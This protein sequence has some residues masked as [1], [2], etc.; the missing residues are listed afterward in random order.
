MSAYLDQLNMKG[1]THFIDEQVKEEVCPC[2]E[3]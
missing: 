2:R 3:K 1:M